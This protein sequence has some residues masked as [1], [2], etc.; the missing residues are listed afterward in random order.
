MDSPYAN[1]AYSPPYPHYAS[2]PQA[3]G[4]YCSGPPRS[5]Y[6][7][8]PAGLYRPPS[9]APAWSYVPPECPTE[10]S[11]LRRQQVPGYSPPQVRDTLSPGS[12]RAVPGMLGL[13]QAAG[14]ALVGL[15]IPVA[16]EHLVL[17]GFALTKTGG[18]HCS[19]DTLSFWPRKA[20]IGQ[21][22]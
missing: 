6:P 8:E 3:R 14:P 17:P 1:G 12:E 15:G 20:E 10:G 2:L 21:Q 22:A 5:P 18:H 13:G 11:A 7:T 16:L 19:L 9:P 4:Y